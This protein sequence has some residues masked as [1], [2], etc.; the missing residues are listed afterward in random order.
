M[1]FLPRVGD[2]DLT[3]EGESLT[4]AAEGGPCGVGH[5]ASTGVRTLPTFSVSWNTLTECFRGGEIPGTRGE[6]FR[7]ARSGPVIHRKRRSRSKARQIPTIRP[8]TIR[9]SIQGKSGRRRN[10]H[11][12]LSRFVKL[13]VL[14]KITPHA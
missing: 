8:L 1:N 9:T 6:P 3:A 14:T 13:S 11:C 12:Q 2:A 10:L 5:Q 7:K 4:P